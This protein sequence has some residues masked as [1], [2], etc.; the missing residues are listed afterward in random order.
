MRPRESQLLQDILTAIGYIGEDTEDL[1]YDEFLRDRRARQFVV[2]NFGII[3]EAVN[4]LRR[5]H[6]AIVERLSSSSQYI[7][8]RRVLIHDSIDYVIVWDI[9][10]RNL[11]TLEIEVRRLLG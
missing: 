10:R 11:P 7:A 8:L 4:R 6:P 3:G 2:Y 9:M 5:L 1:T